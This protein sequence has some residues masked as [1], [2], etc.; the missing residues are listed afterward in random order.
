MAKADYTQLAKEVVAAVGGKENIVNVTNCMTRLRFVLKD[1]SIPDKDKVAGIK[2]VKGVMNQGGQYQV[3][4][5]THVSEVVKDVRREAQISGEGSIN[6]EDMKL[7]KKDSLWN[8]FFKTISGCIMPMLGPMIA[9]GIIKGILVILVTAGILTKTDGTYLVLY[10]A[11]DAILY[12]MPV[13]VGFTCGKVFDCNPY[14]TAV[15][16]AAFLYPDLVSAVSAEGGITFLKIPVAA[17]SYTN[18]FLPIVLAGFV[19]SKLEKLAKKFIPSMLQ[20]M[21]VPTFVLAVTVPLSWIVI[22]P[23]MNTVSSWLSK[24]VFGIFGM[25]PLIGGALLGAFWQLVVLLGLH[26]AFIPILMNNLFSQGYDPVNAVLGLTVWALAGVTLGYALKNK[27][28]EKRGIGFGSLASALCGVT[29]P[30]I[31]SIALPNFK[32]FVC[33]WIGGGIS[34]GILGAL[35][36]KMYTMAGDGLFRIPAMINPE[37][38]DISFYGFI[39]CALISFAVSAVLAFIMADSGVEEAEQVAEQM[40]TDMNN[41]VLEENKMIS[42]NKETI[43]CAPVSGKVICREDIPDETFASG[44][45]G[46]G[47]GIKPEEEIIVAPFDGEITSVVDTGH[48]VGLTSS[49]GVELLIHVGVD[50]V[51]MQGDGF[52]VFVTEG[53]KVKTG[54]KLLKFDRDKIRKAG[55]SDTT[56]VLV[57]NSDDYSSVKTVAENVKQKDTVIIIEK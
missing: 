3:I 24:G 42:D 7:I 49:D 16:G 25:R 30:A 8:R 17:A 33:A 43:I 47:V 56:A 37:G 45:M 53:Q 5:G 39:I 34:G 52:Q 11:G 27:D 55:Y 15:I 10:A 44:I 57:T 23:V 26:A 2:G 12:F 51:K 14:V 28:P 6:K 48:A 18:T 9:G 22:G 36:G 46:E 4:I 21:L 31:Y 29:E 13:I 19:A 54:E 20:L 35:G 41:H 38:L 40:D 32:L 50:T 1:D